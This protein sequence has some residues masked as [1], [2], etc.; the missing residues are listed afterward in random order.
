MPCDKPICKKCPICHPLNIKLQKG[1]TKKR[2]STKSKKMEKMM[3]NG[4]S[5]VA[6][7]KMINS[8]KARK[9]SKKS[10]GIR[11]YYDESTSCPAKQFSR[12]RKHRKH[13]F[14]EDATVMAT[15]M[16]TEMPTEAPMAPADKFF[17][18]MMFW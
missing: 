6:F 1:L 14:G 4:M 18:E 2:F 9:A 10:F 3:S 11:S 16:A 5:P 7:K 8:I 17:N 15:E 13:R 12:K